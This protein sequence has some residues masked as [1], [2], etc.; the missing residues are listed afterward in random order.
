MR[1][2]KRVQLEKVSVHSAHI[3]KITKNLN[4]KF[5]DYKFQARTRFLGKIG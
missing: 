4:L 1:Q 2:S 5:G 3:K